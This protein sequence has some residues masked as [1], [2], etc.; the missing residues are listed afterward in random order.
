MKP[1][2]FTLTAAKRTLTAAVLLALITAL[3]ALGASPAQ[4]MAEQ[5]N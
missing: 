3:L 1:R 2:T 5:G 4:L